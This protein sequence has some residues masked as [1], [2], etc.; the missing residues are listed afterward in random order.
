MRTRL[1]DSNDYIRVIEC[2]MNPGDVAVFDVTG[3]PLGNGFVDTSC[4]A[5]W[6]VEGEFQTSYNGGVK[7]PRRDEVGCS[8]PTDPD[9]KY[10]Y[11]E[12]KSTVECIAGPGRI[13]F[14]LQVDQDREL[15]KWEYE[16]S[17]SSSTPG[18]YII[19]EQGKIVDRGY[20]LHIWIK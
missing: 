17:S 19:N 2:S 16:V 10:T 15:D 1:I 12:G 11:P 8:H 6:Y 18:M 20:G 3:T 9:N 5:A 4:H 7:L 14:V 13:L